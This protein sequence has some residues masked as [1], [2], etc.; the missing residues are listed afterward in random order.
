[1]FQS[2]VTSVG[3]A[4]RYRTAFGGGYFCFVVVLLAVLSI[5]DAMMVGP[6]PIPRSTTEYIIAHAIKDIEL[7]R[8]MVK[9]DGPK[10]ERNGPSG[11]P[12]VPPDT[13]GPEKPVVEREVDQ[14]FG[15]LEGDSGPDTSPRGELPAPI[16]PP[17]P[18]E[19]PKDPIRVGGNI[20]APQKIKDVRPVYSA[21]AQS[22]RIQGMVIIEATIDVDGRVQD[23]KIL[24]SIPLLDS[25]ALDAV[26]QWIFTRPTLNGKPQAVIMTVTV[27]F[28]LQ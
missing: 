19:V 6:L 5:R 2:E 20:Q 12:F 26:R 13:I 10:L 8:P 1:M 24:R 11:P 27:N 16:P 25:S 18:P 7:P 4:K 23:A 21:I 17:P 22:A 15:H 9:A 3:T 28:T 14:P